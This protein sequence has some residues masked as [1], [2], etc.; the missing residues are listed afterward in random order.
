MISEVVLATFNLF[1]GVL[2]NGMSDPTYLLDLLI[3]SV[4]GGDH[5]HIRKGWSFICRVQST[6]SSFSKFWDQ[7]MISLLISGGFLPITDCCVEYDKGIES[8]GKKSIKTFS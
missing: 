5:S 3:L 1:W 2:L 7:A 6:L 8:W 4:R